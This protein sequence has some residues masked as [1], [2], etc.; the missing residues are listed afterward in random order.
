MDKNHNQKEKDL[1]LKIET[2]QG[3][4][5]TIF[6]KTDKIQEVLQA[7]IN[8]FGY[9]PDGKYELR[10]EANP[11]EILKQERTLV[12]YGIKDGDILVFTDLGVAV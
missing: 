6:N 2:T 3:T 12:S 4:W 8:H 1:D 7:V 11:D 9:S 10:T 5:E